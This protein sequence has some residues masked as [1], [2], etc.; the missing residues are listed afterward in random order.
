MYILNMFIIIFHIQQNYLVSKI[1]QDKYV[2]LFKNGHSPATA[3]YT[4]EDTLH[5]AAADE[6]ELITLL[7]DRATSPDYNFV[8]NL[9]KTY[10]EINLGTNNGSKMF[11]KLKEEVQLYN[12]SGLESAILYEYNK[13]L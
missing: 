3:L 12:N 13:E 4:Y 1:T 9:F 7:T 8:Y 11:K 10:K 6:K 2:E 5:L